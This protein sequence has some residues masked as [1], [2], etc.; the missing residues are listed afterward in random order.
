MLNS[1]FP[2]IDWSSIKVVGFDMDG[3]LYDESEFIRQVYRP[4]SEL[5]AFR[6]D[7]DPSE[8][9]GEMI[10]IWSKRGSSYQSVFSDVIG[11]K[12]T[13]ENKS[14]LIVECLDIYRGFIPHLKLSEITVELLQY[15]KSRYTM[16]L[17]SDGGPAL[18]R[19][20][21]NSLALDKWFNLNLVG[22]TGMYPNIRP[23]PTGDILSY[24]DI[25]FTNTPAES[26]IYIGD[27][28][29]DLQFA[30]SNSFQFLRLKQPLL[31]LL[32]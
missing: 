3:T 1:L 15:C 22:F 30:K 25:D 20:K 10:T 6:I 2:D 13:S 26:V 27:R 12:I 5:I 16:F 24:I 32:Q 4:I 9:F 18:Q 8:V 28:D 29:V 11:K 17:V 21:F 14:L 23:K 7:A 31:P 19:N